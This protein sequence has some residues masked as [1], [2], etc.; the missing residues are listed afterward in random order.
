MENKNN[1]E[2]EDNLE[3]KNNLENKDNLENNNNT[4]NNNNFDNNTENPNSNTKTNNNPENKNNFDN[5]TENPNSNTNLIQQDKNLKCLVNEIDK[6]PLF[7]LNKSV[8]LE[9]TNGNIY[10]ISE[11]ISG[12]NKKY[13]TGGYFLFLDLN[14]EESKKKYELIIKDLDY[15]KNNTKAIIISFNAETS[16]G[17]ILKINIL[18]EIS[19]LGIMNKPKI[20]II[21]FSK[22]YIQSNLVFFSLDCILQILIIFLFFY[23]I[24]ILANIKKRDIFL[25]F[26]SP[27]GFLNLIIIFLSIFQFIDFIKILIESH[28]IVKHVS[29]TRIIYTDYSKY[30]DNLKEFYR[31]RGF[32]VVFI[33]FKMSF[34][35]EKII[36]NHIFIF[37]FKRLN[38]FF[39]FLFL[40]FIGFNICSAFC[41][42]FIFGQ[43]SEDFNTFLKS[44][45]NVLMLSFEFGIFDFGT[46]DIYFLF[47]FLIFYK[48]INSI[49]SGLFLIYFIELVRNLQI[50]MNF[51]LFKPTFKK[52]K[53]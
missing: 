1:F 9:Y 38:N 43:K 32:L 30:I 41:L 45:M 21:N 47:L 4:E 37:V 14:F 7:F 33:I 27:P 51:E 23:F 11:I 31:L 2:N 3:N 29:L 19:I 12:E 42:Y 46:N 20:T 15:I 48:L 44:F 10:N 39:V 22:N 5:N 26:F 8:I 52:K 17:N 50:M 36:G 25:Y 35:F 28:V 13:S 18:F 16:N 6:A 24:K 49:I 34:I 53:F 40:F